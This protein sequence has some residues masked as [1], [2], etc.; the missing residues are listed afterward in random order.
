MSEEYLEYTWDAVKFFTAVNPYIDL[1]C[2]KEYFSTNEIINEK[3]V[4]YNM[5]VSKDLKK[6][7]SY[8]KSY[9]QIQKYEYMKALFL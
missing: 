7:V 6:E 3:S 8:Q 1:G 5:M 9:F 4:I 2:V